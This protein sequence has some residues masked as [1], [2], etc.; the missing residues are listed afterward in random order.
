MGDYLYAVGGYSGTTYLNTVEKYDSIKD[1][2]S[3]LP[4]HR[5][6]RAYFAIATINSR[7]IQE[8]KNRIDNEKQ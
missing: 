7:Y 6:P 5:I 3:K 1:T 8:D 2:W 4:S